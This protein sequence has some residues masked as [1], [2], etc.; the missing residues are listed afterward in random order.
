MKIFIFSVSIFISLIFLNKDSFTFGTSKEISNY[1]SGRVVDERNFPVPSA[2]VIIRGQEI[3]T[4]NS[5]RFKILNVEF[6]YD[7]VIAWQPTST[8]V[9]YKNLSTDNPDL[10]LFGKPDTINDNSAVISIDFPEI[11]KGSSA[12]IKFISPDVFYCNNIEVHEGE[13]NKSI[14]V[15]WPESKNILSGKVVFIQKNSSQYEFYKEASTVIYKRLNSFN[16]KLRGISTNNTRTSSLFVNLPFKNFKTKG[17]SVFADFL[18]YDRNADMLL[19]KQD[20]NIFKSTSIIPSKLPITYRVKVSGF[21]DYADGSGF[22]NYVYSKPGA[23]V[24]LSSEVPP[25]LQT[26]SDRYLGASGNTEF[27]YSLGSGTGI[28]VVQYHSRDPEINFYIVTSERTA[29]LNYLSRN[30]FKGAGSVEFKWRVKKYLTYFSVD[31][32]V[33][34]REF[35]PDFGYKAVLYSSERTFKTGYF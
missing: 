32:F 33:K 3:Q 17:Y 18:S 19:A 34:P 26:P 30:E 31:D 16:L 6:P 29:Y 12:V 14:V 15:Y 2:K 27:Y 28:F 25:E 4:D 7:V 35:A 24:N 1:V 9:I 23:T 8:A 21:V 13:K 5:G 20:S 22:V 11:P 10:I